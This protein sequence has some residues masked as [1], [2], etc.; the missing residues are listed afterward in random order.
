[1]KKLTILAAF[2]LMATTAKAQSLQTDRLV[3]SWNNMKSMVVGSAKAMP[4]EHYAY[5]PVE[6]V[7]A[8]G[9]LMKHFST[10]NRFFITKISG[11]DLGSVGQKNK[12]TL[13]NLSTKAQIVADLEASFDYV[14]ST[15]KAMPAFDEK[16]D[17]FG[18]ALTRTEALMMMEHH[19][20]REQGKAITY[21]RMKGVKPV[22]SS[23]WL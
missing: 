18:Q 6:T 8:F 7:S 15:L 23:S 5:A 13:E 20:H 19:L 9:Q 11:G 12:N 2:C 17:M 14:I 22:K 10:S 4:E 21:L 3:Y 1:M 16:I